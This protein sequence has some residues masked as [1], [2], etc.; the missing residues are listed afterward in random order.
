MID[1]NGYIRTQGVNPY[2]RLAGTRIFAPGFDL[3]ACGGTDTGTIQSEYQNGARIS[4]NSWG[5]S[6]CAG[7]Y[8]DGSQAY[9]V[10]V[11]DAD[12][13]APGNQELIVTFSAGNSGPS[14]G[15]VGTPGNGKNMIT[16]GAS[17]NDRPTDEDGNWTDGC[18]IGPTGADNVMDVIGFS[19][20]GPSP[21]GRTKP[22]IIAPGTHI[23]GTASTGAS[24]NGSAVCDSFRPSGQTIVNASS[25]TSHSNPAVAGVA[26]LAYYWI[27]NDRGNLTRESGVRGGVA[28]SP[29]MMKSFLMAH[30]TYLSG[31]GANDNFPS[32]SQGY[33]MPNM[34]LLF[35]DAQKFIVDQTVTF[36]NTGETY[37]WV[38]AAAD[39]SRPVRIALAYT[40]EAGAIGTSPQVNNLDLE[41]DGDGTTYLG[42]NFSG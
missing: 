30:P 11:R 6:G 38:G 13:G 18:N 37:T 14:G 2:G 29:A 19:S 16:V 35:D 1:P 23:H 36:D 3:S 40:D 22:E 39:P 34:T 28:P 25:G 20:R 24:Y 33:G 10:G 27:E 7:S 8:D 9:D 31:V 41:V 12:L 26:S 4:S 5:C 42:N 17:E 32:N 21:G 15:T